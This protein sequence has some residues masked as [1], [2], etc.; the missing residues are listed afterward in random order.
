MMNERIEELMNQ[1]GVP[2]SMPFDEWC[3]KFAE[4]IVRE[5]IEICK[6]KERANL[7]GVREVETA[8]RKHFGVE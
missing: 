6:E 5:C 1:T 3:K 7:Y 2:V 8:I 4:L